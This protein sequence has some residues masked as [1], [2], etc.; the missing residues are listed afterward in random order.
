MKA[1]SY[2]D[3]DDDDNINSGMAEIQDDASYSATE[4]E[5][6]LDI[7]NN[8]GTLS[9]LFGETTDIKIGTD[10]YKLQVTFPN[11]IGDLLSKWVGSSE[12]INRARI[13]RASV[14][15]MHCMIKE[16]RAK[17]VKQTLDRHFKGRY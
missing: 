7:F 1:R 5:R 10:P 15:F 6:E 3:H 16:G 13:I 11:K 14:L 2:F 4:S 17:E 8:K 9:S 12:N